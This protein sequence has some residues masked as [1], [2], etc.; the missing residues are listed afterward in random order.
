L[1]IALAIGLT[2]A[3][4]TGAFSHGFG[5]GG[6]PFASM[7]QPAIEDR[8]DRMV[9]HLAIEIDASA[10]QQERLR[11][12]VKAAVRDLFPMREQAQA[13]R[14]QARELLTQPAVNRAEI[15]RFRT[16]QIALADTASR[17]VAQALAE[18]AEILTLEQ[19]LKI[20]DHLERREHWRRWRRG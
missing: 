12:V 15:E 7:S 13:A 14:T 2:G 11:A 19:R 8:A 16:E 18:I 1:I 5:F 17:R 10:E 3:F 9:R 4:A 20:N 6:G